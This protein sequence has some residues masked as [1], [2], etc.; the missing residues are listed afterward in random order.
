MNI[1]ISAFENHAREIDRLVATLGRLI[2]NRPV[3]LFDWPAYDNAG[4]HFIWLGEKLIIKHRLGCKIIAEIL[5]QNVDMVALT[6]LPENSVFVMHGGGNFGDIYL[7]HQRL[8][9]AI[10]SAFPD[11]RMI[12]MPQTVFF[13]D[14]SRQHR[15][16]LIQ[17]QHPDLHLIARDEES[18]EILTVQMG[19]RNTYL[20]IDSAFALQ[21]V[22]NSLMSLIDVDIKYADLHLLRRD[23]EVALGQRERTDSLDWASHDDLAEWAPHAPALSDIKL[24][25]DIFDSALDMKSWQRLSAAVLL[26][27][28]ARRIVTDR[29]HGHILASMMRKEHQLYDNNYGKNSAFCKIWSYG[30]PCLSF[31]GA[32]QHSRLI[33]MKSEPDN[34]LLPVSNHTEQSPDLQFK[35]LGVIIPYRNR[36]DHLTAL[37]PHLISYFQRDKLDKAI[38]VKFLLVEQD[39]TLPFNRGALLNAGFLAIAHQ[40][41]YVC[42]HD[43]DYLPLWA[44]YSYTPAPTRIIWWGMHSRPLRQDDSSRRTQAPAQ[45]LGAVTLFTTEAFRTVNGFS[46]A[47]YGWGFEDKDLAAR[48]RFHSYA[49]EQRHGTFIPLDHDNAGFNADGSKSSA[50]LNNERIYNNNQLE[51]AHHGTGREGLSSFRGWTS[52]IEHLRL[53]GLDGADESEISYLSVRF[54]PDTRYSDGGRAAFKLLRRLST[55]KGMAR[56]TAIN[57]V[58]PLVRSPRTSQVEKLGGQKICLAM[59]VKNEASVIARCLASVRPLIDHWIIVD[60]G[61]SDGTQEIIRETLSDIPGELHE[62]AWVNFAH[63]RTES[64]L[65]AKPHGDYTLIIDADDVLEW[66]AGFKLP[67][68]VADSYT[69]EIR[70]KTRTYRRTQLIRN[71]LPWRYEGVLHEFLSCGFDTRKKRIFPENQNQKPLHNVQIIMSEDGARRRGSNTDRFRLDAELLEAALRTEHDP[72][73]IARYYFYLGQSYMDAGDRPKALAAY[74][75]RAK[76][77]FWDQEIFI[78]LYRAANIKAE[79]GHDTDEIIHIYLKAH[80]TVAGTRAEALHGAAKLCRIRK[81]HQEG[82]TYTKRGLKIS[83]PDQGLFVERWIYEYGMLDEYAV[84]AYWIGRYEDCIKAST[85]IL[86]G[87]LIPAEQR[88]RIRANM[89]FAQ[90]KQH[91]T[92]SN[93]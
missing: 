78:S 24:A 44:D 6:R 11:R 76:L 7:R 32:T 65:L 9:E 88:A 74:L 16:G 40:V 29:L 31:L 41:D 19:H 2:E 14:K 20:H 53:H 48:V 1:E 66:Q 13:Q 38:D 86:E 60:T 46:N 91:E 28:A 8:R 80:K 35:K 72:F 58:A 89:E 73:L 59:I 37:L 5:L 22:V 54:D 69:I 33:S 57:S 21:P 47:F 36:E 30:D 15:A 90:V 81:R 68:L 4:D 43:V 82:Y 62:R 85:K 77:G 79:L 56:D 23:G 39:D 61:S 63:N 64:L 83:P 18:F 71:A 12:V 3:V 45:G 25:Q 75:E 52:P 51:Y 84:C 92:G 26:F 93:H 55:T 67:A 87:H 70:N 50:W 49:I 17:A 42:F 10:I 27:S 34:S